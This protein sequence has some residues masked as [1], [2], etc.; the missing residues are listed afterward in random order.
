MGW[1]SGRGVGIE[2][3]LTVLINIVG[4][5][6]FGVMRTS[7][8]KK[9]SST[10]LKQKFTFFQLNWNKNMIQF[11]ESSFHSESVLG[12]SSPSFHSCQSELQDV[13]DLADAWC[14]RFKKATQLVTFD[15]VMLI[16]VFSPYVKLLTFC[17]ATLGLDRKLYP[18][19]SKRKKAINKLD[20]LC[21]LQ[22]ITWV[23]QHKI[24]IKDLLRAEMSQIE[25]KIV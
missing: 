7:L 6:S 4:A 22:L 10:Q 12:N 21:L 5:F 1:I 19:W 24:D 20:K 2:P 17:K 13:T 18:W 16:S 11:E 8:I 9:L 14:I 15:G 23:W 25:G 3:R